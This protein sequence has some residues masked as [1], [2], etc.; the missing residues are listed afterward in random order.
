MISEYLISIAKSKNCIYPKLETLFRPSNKYPEYPYEE[1]SSE[2][3]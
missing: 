3:W 1:I 2:I